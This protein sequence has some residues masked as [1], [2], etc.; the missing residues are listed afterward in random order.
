[1]PCDDLSPPGLNLTLGLPVT[2]TTRAHRSLP[3]RVSKTHANQTRPNPNE[4]RI[5]RSNLSDATH[6]P[7]VD[8]ARCCT[9]LKGILRWRS[10]S[11][12]VPG[13]P[14]RSKAAGRPANQ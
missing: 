12:H 5:P 13:V 3:I 9:V 10:H 11:R 2:L 4:A 1:M 6:R 7:L 8:T 14:L